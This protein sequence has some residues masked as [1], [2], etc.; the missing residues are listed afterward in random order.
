MD[1]HGDQGVAGDCSSLS[2]LA[3]LYQQA[4]Q[5]PEHGGLLLELVGHEVAQTEEDDPPVASR[6]GDSSVGPQHVGVRADHSVGPSVDGQ[7]GKAPQVIGGVALVLLASV[8]VADHQVGLPARVLD[9]PAQARL[10]P[11]ALE[12]VHQICL[13]GWQVT[14]VE[15][16]GRVHQAHAHAAGLD[17]ADLLGLLLAPVQA[18]KLD[19]GVGLLPKGQLMAYGLGTSVVGV[20]GGPTDQGEARLSQSVPHGL[21][22]G[23]RRVGAGA[24]VLPHQGRLLDGAGYVGL[25]DMGRHLGKDAREVVGAG[26][27][28]PGASQDA[29]MGY[30]V[31][32]GQELHLGL[33]VG[34]ALQ[35]PALPRPGRPGPVG[36]LHPHQGPGPAL[37]QPDAA[38]LPVQG[39][40]HPDRGQGLPL[41]AV[42]EDVLGEGLGPVGGDAGPEGSR[43]AII[44]SPP[45]QEDDLGQAGRVFRVARIAAPGRPV[46]VAHQHVGHAPGLWALKDS[47]AVPADPH[48]AARELDLLVLPVAIDIGQGRPLVPDDPVRDAVNVSVGASRHKAALSS[49]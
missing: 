39:R 7:A 20:V 46:H 25:G 30:D 49:S 32:G 41:P 24:D 27:S 14:T 44:A 35:A 6:R 22:R 16:V 33:L 29:G 19:L 1:D 10:N 17:Q 5:A 48:P 26:L 34:Q 8:Q 15:P 38:D 18:Q 28:I 4:S 42:D 23:E 21:G 47:L 12:H 37:V 3:L 11:V 36:P 31:A 40:A 43:A 2:P 9:P 45:G 13:V